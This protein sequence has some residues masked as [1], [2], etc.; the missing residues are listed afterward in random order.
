MQAVPNLPLAADQ[1]GGPLSRG[2][3]GERIK[4]FGVTGLVANRAPGGDMDESPKRRPLMG[5]DQI[6]RHI[7][8]AV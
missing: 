4:P 2:T 5:I 7:V 8:D 1:C 6:F 3:F